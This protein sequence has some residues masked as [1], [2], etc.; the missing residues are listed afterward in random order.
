M[1]KHSMAAAFALIGFG[2]STFIAGMNITAII[3][4]IGFGAF[5]GYFFAGLLTAK[6]TI[7]KEDFI[8]MGELRGKT[9][10]EIKQKVG[11]PKA[12]FSCTAA[13]TGRPGT[14]VTWAEPSYSITLL[15]DE[16]NVCLGVNREI[17]A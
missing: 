12:T 14:L 4:G 15:F 13:E 1:N 6:G 8:A 16:N 9:L 5:A 3:I 11:A 7:L 10:D 17:S 2:L